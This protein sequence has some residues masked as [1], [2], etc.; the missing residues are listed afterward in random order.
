MRS[1]T[2]ESLAGWPPDRIGTEPA[3][4]D[5]SKDGTPLFG[6]AACSPDSEL[7]AVGA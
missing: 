7:K 3:T 1:S 6:A 4:S 5:T 2:L